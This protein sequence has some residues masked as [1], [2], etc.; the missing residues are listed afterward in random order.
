MRIAILLPDLGVKTKELQPWRYALEIAKGL[1]Q[2]GH[3]VVV[4]TNTSTYTPPIIERNYEGVVIA[5]LPE[6]RLCLLNRDSF[7]LLKSFD[8]DLLYW[9]GNSLSGIYLILNYLPWPNVL[10]ISSSAYSTKDLAPI[11]FIKSLEN[12]LAVNWLASLR[13]S[14][15]AIKLL[16]SEKITAITVPTTHIASSLTRAGVSQ[17]KIKVLP[18]CYDKNPGTYSQAYKTEP[19]DNV[20]NELRLFYFGSGVFQRGADI[21][22]KAVGV[23]KKRQANVKILMLLRSRFPEDQASIKQIEKIIKNEGIANYV[24]IILGDLSKQEVFEHLYNS[25]VVVLPFRIA[26]SEP[27]ITLFEVMCTGKT[28]ITAS[29]CGI[30]EIVGKD[31]AIL[32]PPCNYHALAEAIQQLVE[33]KRLLLKYSMKSIARCSQL[34]PTLCLAPILSKLFQNAI[35]KSWLNK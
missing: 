8:P 35:N 27:P 34:P 12:G 13:I 16:N 3:E 28:L 4:F 17:S 14:N 10:H 25:D 18:I 19:I 9:F 11:G 32:I 2:Y 23:L 29:S 6:K 22:L 31:N 24:R 26:I 20:S 21:L 5:R 30:P 15:L 1:Y 33:D 7:R